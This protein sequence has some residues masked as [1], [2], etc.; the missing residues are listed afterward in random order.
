MPDTEVLLSLLTPTFAQ[1]A[2]T[3]RLAMKCYF[4]LV[5]CCMVASQDH[6]MSRQHQRDGCLWLVHPERVV[7]QKGSAPPFKRMC[8]CVQG[9]SL[10]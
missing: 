3:P 1:A 4:V 5:L 9:S 8:T 6:G 2:A 10:G 7:S